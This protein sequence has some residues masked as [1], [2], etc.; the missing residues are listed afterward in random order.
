[1]AGLEHPHIVK[2]YDFFP[3][4]K[5]ACLVMSYVDGG[6]LEDLI[7][8]RGR[9][10]LAQ[11]LQISWGIL[12]ALDYAHR[13][14]VVH[15]DVKPSNILVGSDWHAYLVDFGIALVLGKTRMTKFGTNVGT[16]EYMSP[17]QILGKN[18]DHQTDVYSFGCV[19]Y[20]ML[21]GAPP[22]GSS[23]DNGST[24]FTI[25]QRHI[26][27]EPPRLRP[28][29]P[30]VDKR[31]EAVIM[32][33]LAKDRRQRFAG[34]AEML[35]ALFT[36][37]KVRNGGRRTPPVK[38]SRASNF[39]LAVLMLCLLILAIGW[40]FTYSS[41]Q[42]IISA[43]QERPPDGAT[44]YKDLLADEPAGTEA[45]SPDSR[46]HRQVENLTEQ[47]RKAK[48]RSEYLQ[49]QMKQLSME[50][51]AAKSRRTGPEGN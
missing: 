35:S 32:R 49:K 41:L 47:L 16:P 38:P 4:G 11:A 15:R 44:L 2:V 40:V 19:L 29:N 25:M 42:E 20:E 33:A 7:A 18:T 12:N 28:L 3:V 50:L 9:L 43:Q 6:S 1:M 27:D 51:E 30:E 24:D 23:T 45:N 31:T 10:K 48:N 17:E 39:T 34:C 46:D 26:K 5:N 8:N 14:H 13:Q 22:F 37:A 36:P 21:A